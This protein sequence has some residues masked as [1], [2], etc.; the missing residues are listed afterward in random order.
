MSD[1]DRCSGSNAFPDN[2]D[3]EFTKCGQCGRTMNLDPSGR[4][5]RHNTV[6]KKGYLPAS[7]AVNAFPDLRR[8]ADA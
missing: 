3:G 2:F 4:V 8:E 5:P 6:A 7:V 1:S